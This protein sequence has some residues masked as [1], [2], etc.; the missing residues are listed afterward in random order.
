MS[1][2]RVE[3]LLRKAEEAAD[4]GDLEQSER[5]DE[6]ARFSHYVAKQEARALAKAFAAPT[7]D[8]TVNVTILAPA[9]EA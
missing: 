1:E 3:R 5:L 4:R 6:L 9:T 7:V 8:H 2:S